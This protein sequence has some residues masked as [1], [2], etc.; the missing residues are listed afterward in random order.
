MTRKGLTLRQKQIIGGYLFVLPWIIGVCW[1]FFY[2]LWQVGIYSFNEIVIDMTYGGYYLESVGWGH[3]HHLFFEH[4][5]FN[6]LLTDSIIGLVWEL[7]LITFFSLFMAILLNRKFKFRGAVRVI[8]FLPV[9]IATPAIE[10]MMRAVTGVA[11]TG[12]NPDA[13]AAVTGIDAREFVFTLVQFGIPFNV[14]VFLLDA[15]A[16]LHDVIRM[17]GVQILIFLAALQSIPSSMYEVSQIEGATAYEAFWKI[18]LPMISPFILTNII[19]TVV[20]N[21]AASRVMR[22]AVDNAFPLLMGMGSAM[23]IV[24]SLA[25]LLFLFVVCALVSRKVFY[26]T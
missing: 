18:T 11:L 24:S 8:F 6:R 26:Q 3:Y 16:R 23:V 19:F 10:G 14:A 5:R 21:F 1:F 13:G 22:E 4:G 12:I 9:I 17:S 20:N 15:I 2:N 7:P 25:V